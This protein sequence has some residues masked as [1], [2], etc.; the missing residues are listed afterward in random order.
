MTCGILLVLAMKSKL[1]T[2]LGD[3]ASEGGAR[4]CFADEF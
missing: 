4:V 1:K 2:I 3:I